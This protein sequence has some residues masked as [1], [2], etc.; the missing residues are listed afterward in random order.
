MRQSYSLTNIFTDT[1]GF[2]SGLFSILTFIIGPIS[3]Y[4]YLVTALK[5]LYLANTKESDLFVSGFSNISEQNN[6]EN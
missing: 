3:E 1:G 6:N 2:A 4:S 5:C